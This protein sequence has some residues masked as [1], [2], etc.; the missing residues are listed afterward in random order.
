MK[1]EKHAKSSPP[2]LR[3]FKDEIFQKRLSEKYNELYEL[4]NEI[5]HD[6]EMF[7]SFIGIIFDFY[8][9][10]SDSFKKLDL[11]RLEDPKWFCKNYSIGV[12][13]ITEKFA[14]NLKGI[15]TKLDYL[16]KLGVKFVYALPFLDTP[17]GKSDGGFAVSNYRKVKEDLGTIEDLKHLINSLH[18]RDMCFCMNFIINHTSDE[19]EWAKRAKNGEIE[20]QNRY[21]FYDSWY[22][23][24]QF[25]SYGTIG[26]FFGD[27]APDNFTYVP[28]CQKIVMTTFYPFQWDVNFTNPIVFNETLSNILFLLNLGVDF[29][30]F[31]GS[32]CIWKKPG[33]SCRNLKP[34]YVL[35]YL[36]FTALHIACPGVIAWLDVKR[37]KKRRT[38]ESNDK[39]ENSESDEDDSN[40]DESKND[41]DDFNDES[42]SENENNFIIT[43]SGVITAD[44]NA[45]S[46]KM[47]TSSPQLNNE[48][49]DEIDFDIST[50]I[51]NIH[52]SYAWISRLWGSLA[53]CN[54]RSVSFSIKS[55]CSRFHGDAYFTRVQS[56]DDINWGN[57]FD[58][59]SNSLIGKGLGNSDGY[60]GDIIT[61]YR[62]L[63]DFYTGN[64]PGSFSRGVP[65]AE[66]LVTGKARLCG[67]TASLL[68]LEKSLKEE[69]KI[70]EK[71][72][73]KVTRKLESKLR[74]ARNDIEQ[75]IKRILL[76]HAITASLPSMFIIYYGDE[77]G[78][79]NDYKAE[80]DGNNKKD[81]RYVLRGTMDWEKTK[82]IDEDKNSY[83][84]KIFNG[85]KSIIDAR[86][87]IPSFTE[88]KQTILITS[89]T[90]NH[91]FNEGDDKNKELE[92]ENGIL[93]FKRV[94]DND[95][96]ILFMFSF[97]PYDRQIYISK[98]DVRGKFKN[99]IKGETIDQINNIKLKA[100]EYLWLEPINE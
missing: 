57:G 8:Q 26:H 20:Y 6:D 90:D 70:I 95:D 1:A 76:F 71:M 30:L 67:R 32:P 39:L 11:K 74:Q 92:I 94:L 60:Q 97:Y 84:S 68:G 73:K 38:T 33:T 62:Y 14:G 56:H 79:L 98:K 42:E 96:F 55:I 47:S 29:L 48:E 15:E 43:D 22:I 54:I 80:I 37:H 85:I 63:N 35:N 36:I 52:Y 23:P 82:L 50:E 88:N 65:F 25:D 58:V 69:K 81:T 49:E 46:I 7:N 34:T 59:E 12:Q 66:D 45:G 83:Q 19:H 10:R 100:Y 53:L 9:K 86:L 87:K 18:E 44:Q 64:M 72:K 5:Y 28:E 2:P 77:I 75:S 31:N 93:I 51:G 61:L 17:N 24:N 21:Y 4:Y 99:L 91:Y 16:Q 41:D 89:Y 78:T 27:V 13:I 3:D 40:S